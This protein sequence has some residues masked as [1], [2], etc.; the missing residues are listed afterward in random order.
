MNTLPPIFDGICPEVRNRKVFLSVDLVDNHIHL[1][2]N[3]RLQPRRGNSD[4][5]FHEP[6]VALL[7]DLI[8]HW[9]RKNAS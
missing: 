8:V 7:P 3:L 1:L 5:H 2:T 9:T 4:G 6:L